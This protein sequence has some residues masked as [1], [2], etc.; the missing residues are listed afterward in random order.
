MVVTE[1]RSL[2]GWVRDV[3][4]LVEYK[5]N[6]F[7]EGNSTTQVIQRPITVDTYDRYGQVNIPKESLIDVKV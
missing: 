2:Y 7:Q 6:K 1:T 4:M 3:L 5:T